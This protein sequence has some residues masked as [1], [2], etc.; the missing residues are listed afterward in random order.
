[1]SSCDLVW[2]LFFRETADAYVIVLCKYR[3][4]MRLE[5]IYIIWPCFTI[6]ISGNQDIAFPVDG[7]S[8]TEN[9][10]IDVTHKQ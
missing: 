1:M 7:E 2:M 8:E 10:E 9:I 3:T 5:E 4:F 6:K